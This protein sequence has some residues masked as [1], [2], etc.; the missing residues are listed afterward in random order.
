MRHVIPCPHLVR[1]PALGTRRLEA[2]EVREAR[3]QAEVLRDHLLHLEH[4]DRGVAEDARQRHV[5]HHH[6]PIG[7]VLEAVG[8]D[9]RP[10]TLDDLR[11]AQKAVS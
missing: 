3:A 6:A 1:L 7:V 8:L 10:E 5:G 4:V 9:V 11:S 2:H